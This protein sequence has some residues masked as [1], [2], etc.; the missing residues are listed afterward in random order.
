MAQRL[1]DRLNRSPSKSS[2]QNIKVLMSGRTAVLQ[3]TVDAEA[4]ERLVQRLLIL[5]PGVDSVRSELRYP[6]K[7]E[8]N[9]AGRRPL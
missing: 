4:D 6:G 8:A 7:V 3:G 2:F 9:K 5:E 1:Q